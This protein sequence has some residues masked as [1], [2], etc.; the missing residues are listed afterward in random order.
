MLPVVFEEFELVCIFL[1][2]F[3]FQSLSIDKRSTLAKICRGGGDCRPQSPSFLGPGFI[4]H[5]K[6][7]REPHTQMEKSK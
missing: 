7:Y 6:C 2:F 4:V 3:S 1:L 5:S